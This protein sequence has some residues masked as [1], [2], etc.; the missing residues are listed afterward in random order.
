MANLN[1]LSVSDT[2]YLKIPAATGSGRPGDVVQ[3]FTNVGSTTFNVPTGVTSVWVLV[4]A[5]GGGG[6]GIVSYAG[7]GGGAGGFVEV[8][9]YPVTPGGSVSL[10]VG[11]GGAVGTPTGSNGGN[12][13]FGSLIAVGGGGG[14][15]TNSPGYLGAP[16]GAGGGAAAAELVRAP[17]GD[18]AGPNPRGDAAAG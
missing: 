9:S 3:Y 8:P 12:S 2:G 16:G 4:V 1:S 10:S 7:G 15:T 13:T 14:G 11:N 5:G 6:G 17:A 18:G